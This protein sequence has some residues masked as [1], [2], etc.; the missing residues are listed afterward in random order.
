[1]RARFTAPMGAGGLRPPRG[2]S[3]P[4]RRWWRSGRL[5][6][7]CWR[8]SASSCRSASSAA[9]TGTIG[10]P[11]TLRSARPVVDT[12][13]RLLPR[14]DGAGHPAHHRGGVRPARCPADA[15]AVRPVAASRASSCFPLGEQAEAATWMGSRPCFPDFAAGD[16]PRAG[17]RRAVARLWPCPLGIDA[18]ARDRTAPGRNDDGRDAVL[19]SGAVPGGTVRDVSARWLT[20]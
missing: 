8:R 10:R 6:L 17:T 12:E 20:R 15:G 19:R 1:M 3:M 14:A 9:I 13:N 18:R 11:A 2:R 7:T 5:R 4:R 16:R